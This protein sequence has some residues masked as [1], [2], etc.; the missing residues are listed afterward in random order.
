M[1]YYTIAEDQ[2]VAKAMA[3]SLIRKTPTASSYQIAALSMLRLANAK[4]HSFC[5]TYDIYP[6]FFLGLDLSDLIDRDL[7]DQAAYWFAESGKLYE[8]HRCQQNAVYMYS[9]AIGLCLNEEAN[10]Q[11]LADWASALIRLDPDNTILILSK[12]P[13][14]KLSQIVGS[15]AT[16]LDLATVIKDAAADPALVLNVALLVSD[17]NS[18]ATEVAKLLESQF[19]RFQATT[20]NFTHFAFTVL[21]LWQLSE[22]SDNGLTWLERVTPLLPHPRLKPLFYIWL[23]SSYGQYDL[24]EEWLRTALEDVPDHPEVLAAAY[25]VH[26]N[27][28]NHQHALDYAQ[29]LFELV[30]TTQTVEQYLASLWHINQLEMFLDILSELDDLGFSE[31]YIHENRASAFIRLDRLVDARNDLEWI[32]K[33][34]FALPFHLFKLANSYQLLGDVEQAVNVLRDCVSQ[35]P[36]EI[37]VYLALSDAYLRAN[38]LEESFNW[39]WQANQKFPDDP[40]AALHLWYVSH[41]TGK[42]SLSGVGDAF[43]AFLSGGK[44]ADKSPFIRISL[45]ELPDLTQNHQQKSTA[46]MNAYRAGKITWLMLCKWSNISPFSEHLL[47]TELSEHKGARYIAH[48]EQL[49]DIGKLMETRP[50]EVVL[51][52]TALLTIWTLFEAD[53]LN[54]LSRYFDRV[55]MPSSWRNLWLEEEERLMLPRQLSRYQAQCASRDALNR[56]SGKIV[57]Y[58]EVRPE[59]GWDVSGGHTEKVVAQQHNLIYLNEHLPPNEPRPATAVGIGGLADLLAR[60]GEISE[61]DQQRVKQYTHEVDE[62]ELVL[63]ARLETERELLVSIFTLESWA[64]NGVSLKAL[65]EYFSHIHIA[66][67]ARTLLLNDITAYELGQ[68]TLDTFRQLRQIIRQGEESGFIRFEMIPDAEYTTR[69]PIQDSSLSEADGSEGLDSTDRLLF[70]YYDELVTIA[71]RRN[72]PVWADDRLTKILNIEGKRPPFTFSTDS[73]LAFAHNHPGTAATL[74]KVEYHAYY[75]QL[76]KWGYFFLPINPEHILWHLQQ[77]RGV[78][79]KPL[80]T[81]FENYRRSVVDYWRFA[82]ESPV[83]KQLGVESLGIYQQQLIITLY[84]LYVEKVSTDVGASIF[85][86]LDL[87]RVAGSLIIGN[88][89]ALFA[90]LFLHA[91]TADVASKDGKGSGVALTQHLLAYSD[92]LNLV[93]LHSGIPFEVLDEAWY[94]LIRYPLSMLDS[95]QEEH[96]RQVAL[97]YFGRILNLMPIHSMDYLL[98]TDIGPRLQNDFGLRLQQEIAFPI[99]QSTGDTLEIR[100]PTTEWDRDLQLATAKYLE[101]PTESAI[102][103]GVVTLKVRPVA[104]GSL[105]LKVQAIPTEAYNS[106]PDLQVPGQFMLLLPGFKN[107]DIAH[108]ST[109]WEIGLAALE[110]HNSDTSKWHSLHESFLKGGN[111]GIIT[112]HKALRCLLGTWRVAKE[113]LLQAAQLSANNVLQIIDAFTPVM[114]CDWLGMPSLDWTSADGLISWAEEAFSSLNSASPADALIPAPLVFSHSIF[115]DAQLIRQRIAERLAGMEPGPQRSVIQGLLSKAEASKSLAVKANV[116]LVMQNWLRNYEADL[117]NEDEEL[118]SFSERIH[119]QIC[120]ILRGLVTDDRNQV[121]A[122]EF[123]S[124]LCHWFYQSWL[125][126]QSTDETNSKNELTYL[127]CVGAS[128]IVDVLTESGQNAQ[129]LFE[130][131]TAELLADLKSRPMGEMFEQQPVGF[132]RPALGNGLNYNASFLLHGLLSMQ[133]SY[134]QLQKHSLVKEAAL[135]CAVEYRMRQAFLNPEQ[136]ES[137]WLDAELVVDISG[138]CVVLVGVTDED[139]IKEWSKYDQYRV[140][141]AASPT[142]GRVLAQ[143][144][145]QGIANQ[146]SETQVLKGITTLFQGRIQPSRSWYEIVNYLFEPAIL[147][148]IREFV[149]CYGEMI[150]N[151][152]LIHIHSDDNC[153]P[154]LQNKINELLLEIPVGN[155]VGELIKAKAYVFS[156]LLLSG[157]DPAL[158]CQWLQNIA[159]DEQLD[160]PTTRL[161]F[162]PFVLMLE[163]YPIEIQVP[164]FETF[165]RFRQLPQYESLWEFKRLARHMAKV[166]K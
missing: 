139:G 15:P 114:V 127:A 129:H 10:R 119:Q 51:D 68:R 53:I 102:T 21:R 61:I 71:L 155:N 5:Q 55:Y 82:K 48:G 75:G 28:Q 161:A 152:A 90:S 14:H 56:W 18:Q 39:A 45:H 74:N 128:F 84:H 17:T 29:R 145:V 146:T 26:H 148:R 73:F 62:E 20:V 136:L 33:N 72:M 133:M 157:F 110:Q 107:P 105:F 97:V 69:K 109:L 87:S 57:V 64:K 54:V 103:V 24:A 3:E 42:E 158:I 160:V 34:G 41:P 115:P 49:Q 25:V 88:E 16:F 134:P 77:G 151:L 79:S 141:V 159:Q 11:N 164:I 19:E 113:Y 101:S 1:G 116:T 35:F 6:D 121:A 122:L 112:G 83:N 98:S 8:Q 156:Q 131:M 63:I 9:N 22:N 138:A 89:P 65:F 86:E 2:E 43:R 47:I 125:L 59:A 130:E 4:L 85:A 126:G 7:Q 111:D 143:Q 38:K 132:F 142:S 13:K 37:E 12:N 58:E 154:E 36:D 96:V 67:P 99:E 144:M 40:R 137:S 52:Y 165:T 147:E 140:T 30:H 100:L 76:V 95:A 92:W 104:T 108:R 60:T 44:F 163:Q 91:I 32:R 66:E 153:S 50:R 135:V 166:R 150:A 117:I 149:R 93:I 81:L 70:D 23:Y 46:L 78:E 31:R 118:F 80:I 123:E 124:L 162:R 27:L 106:V 94:Q 120:S